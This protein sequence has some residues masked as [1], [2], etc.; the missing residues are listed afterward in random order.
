MKILALALLPVNVTLAIFPLL[1]LQII[2]NTLGASG[3][4]YFAL[5]ILKYVESY[6]QRGMVLGPLQLAIF[7]RS[8][9]P[10]EFLLEDLL[11]TAR[12]VVPLLSS[13]TP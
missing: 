6:A 3:V 12:I 10:A 13:I 11:P 9:W 1:L 8:G 7:S 4:F 2:V 5:T